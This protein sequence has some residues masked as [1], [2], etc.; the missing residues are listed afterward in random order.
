MMIA[1]RGDCSFVTKVR[2]M[3]EAGVAVALIVDDSNE[4]V[5]DI[6]MSD[7]GTGAGVRIPSLLISKSDGAKIIDFL[8]TASDLELQQISIVA[9]F[10]IKR[11]DNR[12]E[13]DIWYSSSNEIALD[14]I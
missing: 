1:E 3:E 12:V 4:D 7:D 11:P 10:E 5:D 2:N 6:V 8:K 14:F 9:D 13:Y